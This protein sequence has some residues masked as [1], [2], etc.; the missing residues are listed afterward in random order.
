MGFE[1]FDYVTRLRTGLK[2]VRTLSD[3][4]IH[5]D[6][7]YMLAVTTRPHIAV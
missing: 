1:E 6:T 7:I 5:S 2:L 3:K 4:M